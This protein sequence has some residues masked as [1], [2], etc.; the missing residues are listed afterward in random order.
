MSNPAIKT[1]TARVLEAFMTGRSYNR[2]QAE[3]Q[4]HDHCLHSTVSTIQKK[5]RIAINRKFET[6]RGYQ[7]IPT[8]CCRYWIE[9]RER[10]RFNA[11]MRQA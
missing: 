2:F 3:T 9:P 8:Q 6:V 7:G 10:E 11:E 4:L 1:K 5:H